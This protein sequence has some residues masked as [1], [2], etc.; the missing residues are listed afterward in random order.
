MVV[1]MLSDILLVFLSELKQVDLQAQDLVL[2]WA[3]RSL[4]QPHPAI[5]GC[6]TL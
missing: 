4:A 5:G 3:S 2:P 6:Q 1:T